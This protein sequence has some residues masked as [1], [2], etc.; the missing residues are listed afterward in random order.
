MHEQSSHNGYH[1]VRSLQQYPLP[2]SI[3]F[4]FL[5]VDRGRTERK[6]N[7][8]LNYL[9]RDLIKVLKACVG[10]STFF[11]NADNK[12]LLQ[13][14]C[15]NNNSIPQL[16]LKRFPSL[17]L[18]A[19]ITIESCL[20]Q[21]SECVLGHQHQYFCASLCTL[22][23]SWLLTLQESLSTFWQILLLFFFFY[24]AGC[25]ATFHTWLENS[26]IQQVVL[27]YM[28]LIALIEWPE[29]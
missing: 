24:L 9:H 16:F 7:R 2:V 23:V 11:V 13:K 1:C 4:T 26:T 22:C 5:P 3:T 27:S 25:L 17:R 15:T 10:A 21:S 20:L 14:I 29:R 12:W 8:L 6:Q 28:V 18:A 19:Y